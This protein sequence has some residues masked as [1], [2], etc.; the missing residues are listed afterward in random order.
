ME[1]GARSAGGKDRDPFANMAP[2]II[3]YLHGEL[4]V[5][6]GPSDRSRA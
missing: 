4:T 3:A 5:S 2:N 1:M 6:V